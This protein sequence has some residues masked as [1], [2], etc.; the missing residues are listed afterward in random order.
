MKKEVRDLL[1]R[2]APYSETHKDVIE[3]F[4]EKLEN[5]AVLPKVFEEKLATIKD[6]P[7]AEPE[8]A[9]LKE[10]LE[11]DKDLDATMK[12]L[13][14]LGAVYTKDEF[15]EICS[16]N[17]FDIKDVSLMGGAVWEQVFGH[18]YQS[19][20][21]TPTLKEVDSQNEFKPLK[22]SKKR[23]LIKDYSKYTNKAG[24]EETLV[25]KITKLYS[26]VDKIDDL[27]E[28]KSKQSEG[29][30]L[31]KDLEDLR[32]ETDGI[33]EK[34]NIKALHESGL[35]TSKMSEW[36]KNLLIKKVIGN[37]YGTYVPPVGKK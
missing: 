25:L 13:D 20:N 31:Q 3:R 35:D 33:L 8:I 2:F 34:F 19:E 21:G 4:L 16:E 37:S 28:I 7:M 29:E 10:E 27:D 23:E 22:F 1:Q 9:K 15:D 36:E 12:L 30:N 14:I 17:N 24:E 6:N 18:T 26:E 5:S 11:A 32:K